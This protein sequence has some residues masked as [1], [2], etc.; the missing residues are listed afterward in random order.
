MTGVKS[1]NTYSSAREFFAADLIAYTGITKDFGLLF[2]GNQMIPNDVTDSRLPFNLACLYSIQGDK[3][4]ALHYTTIA[5][6]LGKSPRD[7]LT[8]PDFDRFKKDA[9]FIRIMRGGSVSS[10]SLNPSK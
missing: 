2:L 5:L 4:E 10:S 3:E 9:D 1:G 6:R 8:D 7:F